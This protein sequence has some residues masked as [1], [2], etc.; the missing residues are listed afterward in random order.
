MPE[1][2]RPVNVNPPVISGEAVVNET[3]VAS[4]GDWDE[5]DEAS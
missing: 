5:E 2:R 4:E 3:L 1:T